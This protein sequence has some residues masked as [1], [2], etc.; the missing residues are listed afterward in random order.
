MNANGL[1]II[2]LSFFSMG[3]NLSSILVSISAQNAVL[4]IGERVPND[5]GLTQR[6]LPRG[7]VKMQLS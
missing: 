2:F 1:I 4:K 3:N 6:H 5:K 7:N